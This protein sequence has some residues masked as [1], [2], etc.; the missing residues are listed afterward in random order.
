MPGEDF[1]ESLRQVLGEVGDLP[2]VPE[3]PARGVWAGMIGRS[4]AVIT[5]L[6]VDLQPA[7]WR[8]TDASGV[9]HR[10][11]RSLLAQDLDT[12]EELASTHTGPLKQQLAGP[13]TLAATIERP[14]GD[15]VLGDHGAR[16][17]L[18]EAL[19]DGIG[20]QVRDLRRRLPHADLLIQIDE[21]ALPGV[22]AASIPTASGFSRHRA[23]HPPEADMALRAVV[24]AVTAAGATPIVHVCAPQVPVALLAGAGFA[25]ISFDLSLAVP[26]DAWAEAYEAGIDLWLGAVPGQGQAQES[27]VRRR[28]ES[29][30]TGLGLAEDE[31]ASRLTVTPSCG[32]AGASP[33]Q[34]RRALALADRVAS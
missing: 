3:L 11:A 8:L 32:L 7:G 19:A 30:R 22:L 26:H 15:K 31:W 24:D 29:F 1:A 16:R 4:A 34:A 18:T 25:A 23:I 14:R 13:W 9:D 10:R 21:P 17:D 5:G 28:I 6:G 12:V 33:S 20:D 2:F 27:D